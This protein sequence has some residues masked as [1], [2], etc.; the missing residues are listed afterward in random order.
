MG[1]PI[2]LIHRRVGTPMG[3][4]CVLVDNHDRG[5]VQQG[6]AVL[7]CNS[8]RRLSRQ[9][10]IRN[11][12]RNVLRGFWQRRVDLSLA[13]TF[14]LGGRK[15]LELRWDVFSVLN[16]VNYALPNNVIDSATTDFGKITVSVGGLE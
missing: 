14:S 7:A 15:H 2:V 5:R 3:F 12:G 1:I 6:S 10:G 11:L 4:D 9:P 8:G 16:T 13:K